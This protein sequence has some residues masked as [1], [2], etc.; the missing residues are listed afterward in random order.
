[1]EAFFCEARR[2][3]GFFCLRVTCGMCAPRPFV[4]SSRSG[5]LEKSFLASQRR[6]IECLAIQAPIRKPEKCANMRGT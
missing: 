4:T 3:P 5:T 2:L 1:M 6:S